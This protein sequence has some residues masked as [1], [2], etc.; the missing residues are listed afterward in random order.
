MKTRPPPTCSQSYAWCVSWLKVN[1]DYSSGDCFVTRAGVIFYSRHIMLYMC[2]CF[3]LQSS[4]PCSEE[5]RR[6]PDLYNVCCVCDDCVASKVKVYSPLYIHI[7]YVDDEH[8]LIRIIA[9][10]C[11]SLQ[12]N[13]LLLMVTTAALIPAQFNHSSIHTSDFSSTGGKRAFKY[14]IFRTQNFLGYKKQKELGFSL[15]W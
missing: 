11:V 6:W 10:P 12:D 14:R 4:G 1:I 2:V 9:V 7:L 3:A 13:T 8:L 5:K 15:F